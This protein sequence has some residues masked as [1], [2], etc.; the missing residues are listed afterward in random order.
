ML[1][2]VQFQN[3]ASIRTDKIDDIQPNLVLTAEF[4]ALQAAISQVM[5]EQLLGVCL[6][7]AQAACSIY[8]QT[9][10]P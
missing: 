7:D 4:P 2:A 9:L 10:H 8:I 3:Q 1:T 5:P 6:T